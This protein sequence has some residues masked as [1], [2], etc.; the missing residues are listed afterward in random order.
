M[1]RLTRVGQ[2][3]KKGVVFILAT[4]CLVDACA[5]LC[6]VPVS[7]LAGSEPAIRPASCFVMDVEDAKLHPWLE[8]L[9]WQDQEWVRIY[10][11]GQPQ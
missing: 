7:L 5:W 11:A 9:V 8:Y 4:P 3:T 6:M 2:T 10:T 1:T